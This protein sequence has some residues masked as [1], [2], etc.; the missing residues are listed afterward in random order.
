MTPCVMV[1]IFKLEPTCHA[2]GHKVES[3]RVKRL[4]DGKEPRS[5][6]DLKEV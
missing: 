1:F 2:V 5:M 3:L 4:V 6:I